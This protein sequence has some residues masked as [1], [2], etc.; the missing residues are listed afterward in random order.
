[1]APE[2]SGLRGTAATPRNHAKTL[3][4]DCDNFVTETFVNMGGAPIF[5]L[6]GRELLRV[7]PSKRCA[8]ERGA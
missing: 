5:A 8:N 2:Q 4:V 1:M 6:S 7:G 3:E